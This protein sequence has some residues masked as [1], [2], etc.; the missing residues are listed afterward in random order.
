MGGLSQMAVLPM[1][2]AIE[3]S[4]AKVFALVIRRTGKVLDNKMT[5]V[6]FYTSREA[7]EQYANACNT[8]EINEALYSTMKSEYAIIECDLCAAFAE[9]A[10]ITPKDFAVDNFLP[11]Q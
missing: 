11:T 8:K 7:A 1:S 9:N 5:S 4:T 10:F 2:N 3:Y 6:L